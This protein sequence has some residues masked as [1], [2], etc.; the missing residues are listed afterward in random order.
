MV[1]MG[2][3]DE[4][5][6]NLF[7][8]NP[9]FFHLVKESLNMTGVAWIDENSFV[10]LDHIGVAIVFIWILPQVGIKVLVKLHSIDL[11]LISLKS[12]VPF[13]S[14]LNDRLGSCQP[15]DSPV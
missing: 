13:F 12:I 8:R 10:S 9:V 7:R 15:F 5:H 11:L 3:G 1:W 2:V 14:S 6:V 4:N